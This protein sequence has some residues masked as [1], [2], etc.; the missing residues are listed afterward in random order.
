MTTPDYDEAP[1][2]HI[3]E[4]QLQIS[5]EPLK[6][7]HPAPGPNTLGLAGS[8]VSGK[9]V[10]KQRGNSMDALNS[11]KPSLGSSKVSKPSSARPPHSGAVPSSLR[12]VTRDSRVPT[13]SMAGGLLPMV[14]PLELFYHTF[15]APY[16]TRLAIPPAE[17]GANVNPTKAEGK[18]EALKTC[19]K[20]PCLKKT[21]KDNTIG[22]I[23][24]INSEEISTE[25]LKYQ[26]GVKEAACLQNE[27]IEAKER[28]F[29]ADTMKRT[30]TQVDGCSSKTNEQSQD[31]KRII[32]EISLQHPGV[33]AQSSESQTFPGSVHNDRLNDKGTQ[34]IPS[35]GVCLAGEVILADDTKEDY[36]NQSSE[37]L[38]YLVPNDT[39]DTKAHLP[40]MSYDFRTSPPSE[41]LTVSLSL[42]SF[43]DIQQ[44]LRD[45][46]ASC[47][48]TLSAQIDQAMISMKRRQDRVNVSGKYSQVVVIHGQNKD[49]EIRSRGHGVGSS[50]AMAV[51]NADTA[52]QGSQK[53]EFTARAGQYT[54]FNICGENVYI[55]V[56]SKKT[57]IKACRRKNGG[58]TIPAN[59]EERVCCS[60]VKGKAGALPSKKKKPKKKFKKK[61]NAE[62]KGKRADEIG[63]KSDMVADKPCSSATYTKIASESCKNASD[64]EDEITKGMGT[65]EPCTNWSEA[66]LKLQNVDDDDSPSLKGSAFCS[67]DSELNVKNFNLAGLKLSD[68]T[69]SNFEEYEGNSASGLQHPKIDDKTKVINQPYTYENITTTYIHEKT[70]DPFL[71]GMSGDSYGLEEIDGGWVVVTK[72]IVGLQ[73][74]QEARAVEGFEELNSNLLLV[75]S[76]V[77]L[78]EKTSAVKAPVSCTGECVEGDNIESEANENVIAC[79]GLHKDEECGNVSNSNSATNI[80]PNEDQAEEVI[81]RQPNEEIDKGCT[82]AAPIP[83]VDQICASEIGILQDGPACYS[84]GLGINT[85]TN[86]GI[87]DEE[88]NSLDSFD[89]EEVK[90]IVDESGFVDVFA[91]KRLWRAGN[92]TLKKQIAKY[93]ERSRQVIQLQ[94]M[95]GQL[96]RETAEMK[97]LIEGLDRQTSALKNEASEM[98]CTL[99]AVCDVTV[100]DLSRTTEARTLEPACFRRYTN[101]RSPL[102]AAN[103]LS[104]IR[105]RVKALGELEILTYRRQLVLHHVLPGSAQERL[106]AAKR[107]L[108][109]I[110]KGPKGKK[111]EPTVAKK[112]SIVI[113]VVSPTQ[114]SAAPGV[115]TPS[116]SEEVSN[117]DSPVTISAPFSE[118]AEGDTTPPIAAN[119][120]N[121]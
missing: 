75:E 108:R 26:D 22:S 37:G 85:V 40:P 66:R 91:L 68:D 53:L 45:E 87:Y 55:T 33:Q 111:T 96:D 74:E 103:L 35:P 54:S 97:K 21:S 23:D 34:Q 62:K 71:E 13:T 77:G 99:S 79:N 51:T 43:S 59:V 61:T 76:D 29:V 6:T 14:S 19:A 95:I 116:W 64:I 90:D 72:G 106:P 36:E 105:S 7:L 46:D 39:G 49:A 100:T 63:G 42:E 84:L 5:R 102:D 67:T 11:R 101:I 1:Q 56:G 38:T 110:H 93:R 3:M 47:A 80:D 104:A 8:R 98:R 18:R 10:G 20:P 120:L 25:E 118:S 82:R 16:D 81:L 94:Q 57:K 89:D 78:Q 69:L 52:P 9:P 32:R 119:T 17:N 50:S 44:S 107:V 60:S 109:A 48:N 92:R 4:S 27:N 117:T 114:E 24:S 65:N 113:E 70:P 73:S 30:G 58:K 88:H 83:S 121:I 15:V 41:A 28:Q 31:S 115:A 12:S 86:L 2:R 112:G